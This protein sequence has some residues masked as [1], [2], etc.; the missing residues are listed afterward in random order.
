M[1]IP[2]AAG[3]CLCLMAADDPATRLL[4]LPPPASKT[5]DFTHDIAP[6]LRKSCHRCHGPEK[7]RGGLALHA[8]ERAL[9]GG[10]SGPAI[11]P[12]RSA[13]SR[14]I[15][16]VAGL[17]EENTMPPEGA[18]DPLSPAQIGLLRAWIDQGARFAET[19]EGRGAAS[20]HWS[21][22]P[23]RRPL[24]PAV[25]HEGWPRNGI[26]H[27]V[28][29]R[30]EKEGLSPAPEAD[31]T[32]LI[33]RLSLDLIGL[34]PTIAEV[35]AFLAD[36]RPDAYDR[37][38]E[39]LLA[40]P[41][42]GECW[43][44]HWL[45]RARYA[46]SNGYEKD[47]ERSIWP[48]RDW[49]IRALNQDMPFD[50][51][52]ID[53][54]AGDLLPGATVEDRIAT[55]FHRNTMINE[56]GGIDIEEF[57][58][59]ALVD[60]LNTTGTVWLGLTIGCAQCH[61]HKYDPITQREYYRLL[62]FLNNA[63][64][65]EIALPDPDITRKRAATEARIS[66]LER[67]LETNYPREGPESLSARMMAWEKPIRPV[68]WSILRPS[69]LVSSK[70]ATLT[71]QEDGSVLASGDKPNNDVY[72]IDVQ[73]NL[74]GIT[75]LRLE[76]LTDPSLPES[77]PGRAPL[78]QVGDF[79]L[80]EFLVS[81][82]P[83]AAG[84]KPKPVMLRR[85]TEDYAAP[86][87]SAALAIDGVTDTGWSVNGQVGKPHAAV[88]EL[89]DA[90]EDGQG[91]TLRVT[92]HQEFIHQMT[93]GRFRLSATTD[94]APVKA[95]GLPAEVEEIFLVPAHERSESQLIRLKRY[96]LSVAP[97]L[98]EARRPIAAL[99]QSL[100]RYATTM[101]L[102][103]RR[104]EHLRTTHLHKRGE[105]LKLG[106]V[107]LPGVPT[108][109]HPLAPG[110]RPDRLT[111]ARW[112]VDK[113]NPLVGRVVMNQI[114]QA[115]FGR[116]IVST[117][118]D[119]GTQGARPTHPELL[120]WLATE[121]IQRGWSMK[122]MS[123][124]IVQSATYRQSSR[125]S[126]RLLARD[127][128]N[129]LLARG[130]RFRVPA[131]TVRDIA[132]AASGLLTSKLG[133]PSVYPPQPD[134]VTSLAYGMTPWPASQ[135]ADRYRRG[136]Y[137]FLKRTAP[138]AAFTTM[139]A[140]SSETV[141]VRRERSNTPLQALTLLNDIVFVEAARALAV[142][143]LT[144]FPSACDEDRIGHAFR[145]CLARGPRP[146]ELARL[147][148]FR[149]GQLARLEAGELDATRI[150]G[151]LQGQAAPTPMLAPAATVNQSELASWTIIARVI[152][153][154]DETVT[155]E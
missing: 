141:C 22:R 87:R 42:Y 146:D 84:G 97:A 104:P 10:D 144:E 138:Y 72:E 60:R 140:P 123:R 125:A 36:N 64:E 35:N 40:S 31:R 120:E 45:D 107:T 98:A 150:V 93:I 14:M 8:A 67:A 26:D 30:L 33:R 39:R 73:T 147:E 46:D 152:L 148:S 145:L 6:L 80:T 112:L 25:A 131:E 135:G 118:E 52:T 110:S 85:A 54:I 91:I 12:G 74:K 155:K 86:G 102:E 113:R 44:R 121:F 127:P 59:A 23:P 19:S 78:F 37:L 34:P 70:H 137:T 5:I 130:P 2:I 129:E 151:R 1:A 11:V 50:R 69:R 41:H 7:H 124:L 55:G 77:G 56:E 57:R 71:V 27:F 28:L 51:F 96:Y 106:E 43:G 153:N 90:V 103:E 62:A 13:E 9:A 89:Q 134:G 114:W 149:E 111:L 17:D 24:L 122:A 53:Q 61:S 18:G 83:A 20:E 133:G 99:R 82:V 95:S 143:V 63:D 119:F 75:A 79:L 68:R 3:L 47:R 49:V 154:L 29:A 117:P 136:L 126:G 21:F 100:P 66:D 32:T 132:L 15:R 116:G 128:K 16:Y 48:Y 94:R 88:F 92:M 115:F 142:R 139:D 4:Q 109:L 81:S 76:V 101:V 58:Y 38:V 65:P 108:V 105:F